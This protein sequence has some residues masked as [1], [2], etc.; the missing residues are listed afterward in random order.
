M[1]I[2]PMLV[3]L[4]PGTPVPPMAVATGAE[5]GGFGAALQSAMTGI[6]QATPATV[7]ALWSLQQ[8]LLAPSE[9][10][11]H[12]QTIRNFP[13]AIASRNAMLVDFSKAMAG[14]LQDNGFSAKAEIRLSVDLMGKVRMTSDHPDREAIE[15]LF[16]GSPELGA[17]LTAIL[18]DTQRLAMAALAQSGKATNETAAALREGLTLTMLEN[19]DRLTTEVRYSGSVLASSDDAGDWKD[20]LASLDQALDAFDRADR[21]KRIAYEQDLAKQKLA[22]E[23]RRTET[24]TAEEQDL[25]DKLSDQAAAERRAVVHPEQAPPPVFI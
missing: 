2:D 24:E 14:V 12:G 23:R 11:Y 4:T 7:D 19:P 9:G 10:W 8:R 16:N 13:A 1:Q 15:K 5:S 22:D 20:L 17:G 18:A 21:E 3:G 25:A 6:E